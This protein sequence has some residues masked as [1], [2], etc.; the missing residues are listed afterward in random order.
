VP[1]E[2]KTLPEFWKHYNLLPKSIQVRA[3]EQFSRFLDNPRHGSLQLKPVGEF[4]SVRVTEGYRA[5]AVR[6]QHA[7]VWF[8]IGPHDEYE[9][10]IKG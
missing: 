9:R 3:L 2:S 5:L 8:W 1:P 10:M 4:W 7:F 6:E